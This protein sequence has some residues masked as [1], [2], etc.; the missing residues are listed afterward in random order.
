MV[1]GFPGRTQQYLHSKWVKFITGTMN[2]NAIDM[3]ESSLAIID[4]AMASSDEIRI[5]YASKQAR[6]ANSWK[7]WIGE[8][9]GLKRLNAISQK[10]RLETEY[11]GRVNKSA[12]LK[13]IYGD[14]I[15]QLEQ[16]CEEGQ[17]PMMARSM[18]IE[19]FYV[20][21]EF[22]R[23]ASAYEKL[24]ENAEDLDEK[25]ELDKTVETSE[26]QFKRILQELPAYGGPEDPGRPL[27]EVHRRPEPQ[28]PSRYPPGAVL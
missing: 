17:A 12:E 20:G 1:Y 14:V 23:F 16:V 18:L 2:P 22:V 13:P 5:Q 11:A 10:V 27:S 8:N 15:K 6:I 25:G 3:R 7:K 24:A 26:D 4:A 28:I 21:P 9:R 19:F